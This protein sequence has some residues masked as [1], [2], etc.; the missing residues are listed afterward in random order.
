M[1]NDAVSFDRWW[2][3]HRQQSN[4]VFSDRDRALALAAWRAAMEGA[5]A[6]ARR[7]ALAA[8]GKS[9]EIAAMGDHGAAL[10]ESI[11]ADGSAAVVVALDDAG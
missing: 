9:Q 4:L 10:V 1:S 8:V 6:V 2:A 5:V 7:T 11:R 3:A